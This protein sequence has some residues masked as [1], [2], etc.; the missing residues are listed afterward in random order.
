MDSQIVLLREVGE[1]V[2]FDWEWKTVTV[3]KNVNQSQSQDLADI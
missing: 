1:N 2:Q 3:L